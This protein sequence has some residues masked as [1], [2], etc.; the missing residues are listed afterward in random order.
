MTPIECWGFV[1]EAIISATNINVIEAY[2]SR[3][4]QDRPKGTYATL[5]LKK[6]KSAGASYNT[7]AISE[8][9][10]NSVT[11][12]HIPSECLFEFTMRKSAYAFDLSYLINAMTA[13][14]KV[15]RLF[16]EKGMNIWGIDEH[17]RDPQKVNESY[18]DSTTPLLIIS[19]TL[20]TTQIVGFADNLEFSIN[21]LTGE[22]NQ[23]KKPKELNDE[24]EC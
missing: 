10:L 4:A 14:E 2:D 1:R 8:D 15:R 22:V 18:E 6:I 19:A 23:D 17:Y 21:G 7:E 12:T 9:G 13:N 20:T 24:S 11:T 16:I 3:K 5:S